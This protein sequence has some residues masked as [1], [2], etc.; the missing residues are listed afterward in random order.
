MKNRSTKILLVLALVVAVGLFF[1]FDLERFMTLDFLKDQQESFQSF[2][3]DHRMATLGAF[4]LL[5]VLVTALS[6]PGAVVMTIAAGLLFGLWTGVILVSF[7]S[8]IGA[9]L[10]FLVSRFLLRNWVQTKFR[11]RLQAVNNGIETEGV[12]YLFTLRLVPIFPFFVINLVMGLTPM[13]TLTFYWVSQLGMLPGT[14]VYVNAGTQLGRIESLSGILS[15]TLL[16]S[17]ALLGIFPLIVRKGVDIMKKR[18]KFH[19]ED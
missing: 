13:R 2:Y 17:F 7:A 9:T 12:F 4:F 10:A 3:A 19:R 5:Y 1:A 16:F 8:T 18:K 15:P 6:L 14:A 11:N